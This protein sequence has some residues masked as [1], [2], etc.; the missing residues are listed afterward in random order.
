MMSRYPQLTESWVRVVALLAILHATQVAVED[1]PP[2]AG[3]GD[4]VTA[5][6]DEPLVLTRDEIVDL[7]E[8]EARKLRGISA[9]RLLRSYKRRS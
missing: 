3:G 4:H 6:A 9:R 7:L 1:A 8:R 2:G 5:H